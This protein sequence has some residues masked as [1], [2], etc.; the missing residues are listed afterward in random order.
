MAKQ[1]ESDWDPRVHPTFWINQASRTLMRRFE[2]KL[3]PLGLGTAYLPVV[4]ALVQYGPQQ[5]KDLLAHVRIEQPTMAALLTRMERDGMIR[6]KPDPED[7]RAKRISLT[8]KAMLAF[9]HAKNEL[10][11]VVEQALSGLSKTD[12][13][14]LM[15][16]L[17]AIDGN[18]ASRTEDA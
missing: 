1:H 11:R 13:A 9:E 10:G 14:T 6:R 8:P 15:R 3:R 17:K 16:L 7:A 5:Q 4:S 18:L 12:Q 2:E